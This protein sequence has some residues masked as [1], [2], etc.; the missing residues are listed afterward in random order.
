MKELGKDGLGAFELAL[1]YDRL[2][3]SDTPV[4]ARAGNDASSW[5]LGLNWYFNPYAK[6]MFNYIRF[7]G[8]NTPLDP[9]G[10]DTAGDVL[11]TRLHLDF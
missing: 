2:D 1:R 9:I 6:L 7:R 5:T 10:N 11:A 3:L 4:L 8:D